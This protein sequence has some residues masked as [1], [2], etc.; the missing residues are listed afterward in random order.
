MEIYLFICS[1]RSCVRHDKPELIKQNESQ[2]IQQHMYTCTYVCI[3][4]LFFSKV[5]K[6]CDLIAS[7]VI[8]NWYVLFWERPPVDWWLVPPRRCG[9]RGEPVSLIPSRINQNYHPIPS[10]INQNYH[11]IPLLHFLSR[12][13]HLCGFS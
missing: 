4:L 1:S 2:K 5:C 9:E 6:C 8:G 11:P 12:N 10:R 7:M 3:F 13:L